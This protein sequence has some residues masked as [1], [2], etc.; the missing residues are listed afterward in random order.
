MMTVMT[1]S[2]QG[3]ERSLLRWESEVQISGLMG[4]LGRPLIQ[5]AADAVLHRVFACV[6]ARLRTQQVGPDSAPG[7][8][9]G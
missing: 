4:A 8:A 6:N 2:E 9:P 1:L 7:R 3:G 5:S